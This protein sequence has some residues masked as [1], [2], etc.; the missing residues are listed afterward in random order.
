V[1]ERFLREG[2]MSAHP[3]TITYEILAGAYLPV[4]R[5]LHVYLSPDAYSYEDGRGVTPY[6]LI[7]ETPRSN[8]KR[9]AVKVNI[10]GPVELVDGFKM[11][12]LGSLLISQRAIQQVP[13]ANRDDVSEDSEGQDGDFDALSPL[14]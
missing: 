10:T 5:Q 7:A 14:L 8:G 2:D 12:R 6:E 13:T 11:D 1:I 3:A 9:G 4:L